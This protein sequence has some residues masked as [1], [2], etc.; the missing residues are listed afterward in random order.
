MGTVD[1]FAFI[2]I[3]L[4]LVFGF[5]IRAWKPRGMLAARDR[6]ALITGFVAG[7]TGFAIGS[8][9]INWVVVPVIF[10]LVAVGLLAAGVAGA[11]LRWPRLAWFAG[12]KP[13][14]R[15]IAVIASMSICA[16]IIG[17]AFF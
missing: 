1:N 2:A 9:L 7:V 4:G 16:L 3:F 11:V 5:V 10:W 14:G 17:V 15:A 6:L 8:L 12:T 13:I